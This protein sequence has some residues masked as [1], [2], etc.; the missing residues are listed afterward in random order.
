MITDQC[1]TKE[2]VA[3][4][5]GEMG[6]VDPALLERSIHALALLCALGESCVPFVFKGGT[7]TLTALNLW[8]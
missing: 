7:S 1:F 4:K 5:R 2:W 6:R 8:I 3:K